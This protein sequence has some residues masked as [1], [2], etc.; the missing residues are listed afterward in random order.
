AGPWE[1]RL[2]DCDQR[3]GYN[4]GNVIKRNWT[5]ESN[6]WE[7]L[8]NQIVKPESLQIVR[9]LFTRTKSGET[10]EH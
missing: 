5:M 7:C 4:L 2:A 8:N 1:Q 3:S 9:P 6:I 10:Y